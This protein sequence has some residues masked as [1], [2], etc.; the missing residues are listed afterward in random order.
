MSPRLTRTAVLDRFS[1]ALRKYTSSSIVRFCLVVLF[2]VLAYRVM[3]WFPFI[4]S[5]AL[6]MWI[7][8][9]AS[10]FVLIWWSPKLWPAIF[11][12][13]IMM[14]EPFTPETIFE[15]CAN[16]LELAV[17]SYVFLRVFKKRERLFDLSG[18]IGALAIAGAAMPVIAGAFLVAVHR[19]THVTFIHSQSASI[20]QWAT[21]DYNGV[22]LMLP[23]LVGLAR[24]RSETPMSSMRR[25]E[26]SVALAILV[27]FTGLVFDLWI[28]WP[29]IDLG[30]EVI[31]DSFL[32]TPILA[33][34]AFRF[35]QP[36]TSLAVLASALLGVWQTT[37]GFGP[38]A[39]HTYDGSV[40]WLEMFMAAGGTC[41]VLIAASRQQIDVTEERLRR[42]EETYRLLF[43]HNPHPMW[44]FDPGTLRFVEVNQSAIEKYGYS[45]QEF[46]GMTIR[47]IRPPEELRKLS[48]NLA[49]ICSLNRD[50]GTWIH[51]TKDGRLLDVEVS[52]CRYEI[53]DKSYRLILAADITERNRLEAELRQSQKLEALG[54]MAGGVAHDF[55]NLLMIMGSY[56]EML[57]H[58]PGEPQRVSR[59]SARILQAIERAASLT[60]QL[61]AFSRKQV[62]APKQLDL[63]SVVDDTTA[64]I[65][66][67]IGED[68][69]LRFTRSNEFCPVK[70]DA[71]QLTQV[72]L[73]LC[74]NA[75]DA[76][77]GHGILTVTVGTLYSE[78]GLLSEGNE[79]V[80]P[81]RYA[82]LTV[83]DTGL[84][85][86]PE[87]QEHIFEPF[88]TTKD[89]GKGTGLGLATVYGIVK[90][91]G[92]YIRL[93]SAPGLGSEFT[94]YFPQVADPSSAARSNESEHLETGEES[95]LVAEDEPDL[96]A[97]IVDSLR[98]LGYRVSEAIDGRDAL[99]VAKQLPSLDLLVT[100]VVMPRMPG[101]ELAL[102][103]RTRFPRAKVLLMSGYTNGSVDAEH[104][105]SDTI[106]VPKPVSLRALASSIRALLM[107][108]SVLQS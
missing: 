99:E 78:A 12:A 9:G 5:E 19:Y 65:E 83:S 3:D 17:G 50:F 74:A 72:L 22:L 75:R 25:L 47:D 35:T 55:N 28:R 36:W 103:V 1:G 53:G 89:Q 45:R 92:G 59:N 43:M 91:S 60:Q 100:D 104:L 16:T 40:L 57:H 30:H 51:R 70:L 32:L 29:G 14:G 71:G 27:F 41:S 80:P 54:R 62:L 33:W 37:H 108:K 18:M 77:F 90:Q 7:P 68:I 61:L 73:N 49:E 86:A 67:L 64:L 52:G 4:D 42:S 46:L 93:Q 2:H 23:L 107:Q 69:E 13:E 87:M 48:T 26:L 20:L 56:A 105:D 76:M 15:A 97:A 101:T 102:Q 63:N 38:F 24:P 10:L 85:I 106:F 39:R 84:G 95:I 34:I 98:S 44:V 88:F 66:R 81:G 58:Q 11:L 94:L 79:I 21:G 31:G 82:T 96:R 8:T 6:P